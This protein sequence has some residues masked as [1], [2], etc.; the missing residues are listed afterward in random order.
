MRRLFLPLLFA[1]FASAGLPRVARAQNVKIAVVDLQRALNEVEEGKKAKATLEKRFEEK[2]AALEARRAQLEEL[3]TTI[4]SQKV[5]LSESA[6]RDK[7]ADFN[8]QAMQFQQDTMQAQ[9]EMSAMEADLTGDILER[10]SMTAGALAKEQ[11]YGLILEATGVVFA[12][13]SLDIT[14]AVIARFNT[15]K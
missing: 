4:E 8:A 11:G 3:S 2:R 7:E 6:L 5:M 15:K 12:I 9:Q 10:L 13:D 1:L 14:D